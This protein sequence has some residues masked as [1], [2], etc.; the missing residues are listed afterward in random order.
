MELTSYLNM[1]CPFPYCCN[2][3]I[4]LNIIEGTGVCVF[5]TSHNLANYIIVFITID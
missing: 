4:M 3:N 5:H 2:I 1:M